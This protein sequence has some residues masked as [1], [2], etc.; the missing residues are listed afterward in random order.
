MCSIIGS[1][2]R[3]ELV[4]LIEANKARGQHSCSFTVFNKSGQ[5]V[6]PTQRH[7]WPIEVD[8]I[9]PFKEHEEYVLAHAQAPTTTA[10]GFD[11]VH[12]AESAGLKLWHNG[13]IAPRQLKI[14]GEKMKPEP[15][16]TKMLAQHVRMSN[17]NL[18]NIDGSFA[19]AG[20][21]DG[22]LYVFRNDRCPLYVNK[23]LAISSVQTAEVPQALPSCML[24]EL[25]LERGEF[26]S[27]K[28]FSL[29]Q[30]LFYFG[31]SDETAEA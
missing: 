5:I 4:A 7:L 13:I 10:K 21:F 8:L 9:P 24:F 30:A 22:K 26:H 6:V 3:S 19:C 1:S 17:F 31:D 14:W 15:W 18:D 23:N 12:P 11:A 27:V 2:S 28:K 20:W 16:D 29:H 25:D